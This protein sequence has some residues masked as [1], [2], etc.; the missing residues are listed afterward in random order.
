MK[1]PHIS[2]SL[3]QKITPQN[4]PLLF[5]TTKLIHFLY[6]KFRKWQLGS[7]KEN[8][9]SLS[10][11]SLSLSFFLSL[12]WNQAVLRF[13]AEQF[14]FLKLF[15]STGKSHKHGKLRNIHCLRYH[16]VTFLNFGL[17]P[18]ILFLRLG[19]THVY[20]LISHNISFLVYLS[21]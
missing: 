15:N 21:L 1:V 18:Y 6:V 3:K 8:I 4:Y 16:Y 7:P 19:C 12:N 13:S 20:C 2:R 9:L 17:I 10:L 14:L 11:W 5:C